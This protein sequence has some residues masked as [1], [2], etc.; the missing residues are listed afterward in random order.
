MKVP[1]RIKFFFWMLLVV[2]VS[3][4]CLAYITLNSDLN[5]HSRLID[6][7]EKI[8]STNAEAK[9][10]LSIA[11][12]TDAEEFLAIV[13]ISLII[14]I[15]FS[16]ISA[17]SLSFYVSQPINELSD[18][19]KDVAN[20]KYKSKVS[21]ELFD[22]KDEIGQLAIQFNDMID[23]I[24]KN[25]EYLEAEVARRTAELERAKKS[26]QFEVAE[27]TKELNSSNTNLEGLVKER[28]TE[29]ENKVAE[30]NRINEVMLGR[31]LKMADLKEELSKLK[32]G[33]GEEIT[34][35][36]ITKE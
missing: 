22:P 4:G 16:L 32:K 25:H 23:V 7:I 26:L 12:E 30:L 33:K 31:E 5:Y 2:F 11:L 36:Q 6:E 35:L 24:N 13:L 34:A 1:L 20:G 29:L 21:L 27:K 10:T 17:W 19:V 3:I 14:A 9:N 15:I 8:D 18:A 28:T